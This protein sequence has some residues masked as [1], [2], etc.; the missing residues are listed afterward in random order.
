MSSSSNLAQEIDEDR[1]ALIAVMEELRVTPDRVKVLAAWA[2]EKLARLK[3]NGRIV[4]YSPLSRLIELEGLLLG[5]RGK[6]ALWSA[7]QVIEGE[8]P[9]LAGVE[10]I[11]LRRRAEGQLEELERCRL[12]VVSQALTLV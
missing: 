8:Q 11:A 6:L 4:S 10:L 2:A 9:A 3:P 5:V 12:E 7:L 1:D